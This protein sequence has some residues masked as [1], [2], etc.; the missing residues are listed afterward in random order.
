MKIGIMVRTYRDAIDSIGIQ[1]IY[2]SI[3]NW[4][5]KDSVHFIDAPKINIDILFWMHLSDLMVP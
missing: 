4:K 5:K 1:Y 3:R 2:G